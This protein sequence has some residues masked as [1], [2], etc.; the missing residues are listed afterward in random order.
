MKEKEITVYMLEYHYG[1]NPA[2]ISRLKHDHNY[3]LNSIDRFC[4]IFNCKPEDLIAYQNRGEIYLPSIYP[5]H[6]RHS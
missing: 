2:D 6:T 5:I 3:T 4:N 1:L